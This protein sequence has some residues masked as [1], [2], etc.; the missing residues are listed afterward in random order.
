MPLI[1]WLNPVL[2]AAYNCG[3][4]AGSKCFQDT[5][6][7]V[8]QSID[9]WSHSPGDRHLSWLDGPAGFGKSVIARTLAEWWD[10]FECLTGT[11]FFRNLGDQS[12]VVRLV[13]T[14]AYD[15]THYLPRTTQSIENALIKDARLLN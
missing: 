2:D 7:Q 4:Q 5:H 10:C 8:V 1:A 14:L 13:S 12:K 15:L 11:F 9:N 3:P 6:V